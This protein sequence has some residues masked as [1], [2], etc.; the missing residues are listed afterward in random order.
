MK[1][2]NRKENDARYHLKNKEIIK[3][4]GAKYY[5]ENREKILLYN[6]KI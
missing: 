1:K 2:S 5:Q 6:K 4:K 3:V